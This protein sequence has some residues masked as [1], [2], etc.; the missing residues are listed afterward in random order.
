MERGKIYIL[1]VAGNGPFSDLIQIACESEI[2]QKERWSHV[3]V[4]FWHWVYQGWV[5]VESIYP[6]GVR[7]TTLEFWT[8]DNWNKKI[9][10]AFEYPHVV[11]SKLLNN[12]GKGYAVR[13]IARLARQRF[14]PLKFETS[15]DE[16]KE[17]CAELIAHCDNNIITTEMALKAW[18]VVPVDFQ[19]WGIKNVQ[20]F[21]FRK[22]V[23]ELADI[24]SL[25][26]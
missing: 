13:D 5:V 17:Y 23:T 2:P 9:V 15:E 3:A 25:A 24:E 7:L 12:L 16:N 1:G 21:D 26:A 4:A 20:I 11:P 8:Y 18:Q 22:L 14:T 6:V 19:E 10:E